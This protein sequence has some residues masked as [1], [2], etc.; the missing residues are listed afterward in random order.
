MPDHSPSEILL[1]D[2]MQQLLQSAVHD[3][4]SHQRRTGIAA[5]LVLETSG[6]EERRDLVQ[7]ILQGVSRTEELL[8]AIGRYA[9]SLTPSCYSIASCPSASALRFALANLD[10]QIR[11]SGATVTVGELPEL[12]GDRDRLAELFEQLLSNSIKF[13]GPGPPA[14]EIG[15]RREP[16]G[17]LFSVTDNGMGIP[18]KYKD[19]LFIP[20]RR[21]HGADVPGTGL[22]LAISRKIVEAHGGHIWVDA[23]ENPGG[24][25]FCFMLPAGDGT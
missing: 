21:L 9:V 18:A 5:Q 7:Q 20:F 3:L 17:W 2:E 11:E 13:R 14:I 22:G 12:P 1:L 23:R 10:R 15:A 8:A 24:V 16:E 6:E 25:T 19:R 4:R